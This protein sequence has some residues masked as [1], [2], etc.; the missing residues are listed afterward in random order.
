MSSPLRKTNSSA[1]SVPQLPVVLGAGLRSPG[2][3]STQSGMLIGVILV[4][5]IIGQ[6]CWRD[7]L[8]VASDIIRRHNLTSKLL[9][10]WLLQSLCPLFH[11]VPR[12]LGA[13]VV[14]KMYPFGLS[15]TTHFDWL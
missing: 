2:F 12:A 13:G 8:S 6:S 11:N 7:F 14:L 3:F 10:L 5:L 15:S 1:L 9:L 4:Q